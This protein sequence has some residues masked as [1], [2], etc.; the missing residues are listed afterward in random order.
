MP[1]LFGVGAVKV[2]PEKV[3]FGTKSAETPAYIETVGRPTWD[4]QNEYHENSALVQGFSKD[5]A[6]VLGVKSA[7]TVSFPVELRGY[8]TGTVADAPTLAADADIT[9]DMR[10]L[11]AGLGGVYAGGYDG[12]GIVEL[13]TTVSHLVVT[14]AASFVDG[15]V[16]IVNGEAT[17]VTN[18]ITGGPET[19]DLGIPLSAI[20]TAGTKVY[21]T[22]I[23]Y[24]I[25]GYNATYSWPLSVERLGQA[26]TDYTV[27]TGVRPS[28]MKIS[29][30]V[31]GFLTADLTLAMQSWVREDTGGAPK[32]LTYA[33]PA[34][35]IWAGGQ[36]VIYNITDGVRTET[37]CS[38]IELDM[39]MEVSAQK[40]ANK[41]GGVAEWDKTKMQAVI[42]IDPLQ[43]TETTAAGWNFQYEAGK[44][45]AILVQ[46]G[47]T[48]G[49]INGFVVT[50]CVQMATP[51]DADS[52][53]KL[54]KALTF[55]TIGNDRSSVITSD[56][57]TDADP[58]DKEV[59]VFWG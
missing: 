1:Y 41:V 16:I 23:V 48:A 11:A 26:A 29:A 34:K 14:S 54:A 12:T 58:A 56:T 59:L 36:C 31:G 50:N 9:P 57:Y 45:Y 27:C 52:D 44:E 17:F 37:T 2:A 53:S 43:G 51:A 22:V 8:D 46:T 47:T 19:L 33:Y 3:A 5:V 38:K 15:Q 10:L 4:L 49:Q 28:A 6:G 35:K 13:A 39:G 20:P 21:G 24:N 32:A 55:K 42:T 30:E 25:A 18:A 40:D 7:S